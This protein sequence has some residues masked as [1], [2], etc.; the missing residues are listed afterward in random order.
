MRKK[1]WVLLFL[2]A[3]AL[4]LS[5]IDI[6][7]KENNETLH[8]PARVM[9]NKYEIVMPDGNWKEIP[10]KGV[11]MGIAKPGYF[12]GESAITYDEYYR[13]F[14]S[15]VAMNA[16]NIRIYTLH[17]PAFYEALATFNKKSEE[18]LYVFHGVWMNEDLLMSSQD[19]YEETVLNDFQEESQH[20]VDAVH[21]NITIPQRAG[22]SYGE[23][24]A[25]ISEYVLG[26]IMGV[27][28]DPQ[29]V[30][31]TNDIHKERGQFIGHFFET[32][33]ASP[34][35]HFLAQQME[36]MIEYEYTQY[37]EIRPMSFTN[38][39]TTD[40]LTHPSDSTE[41]EDIVSV[42]PNHIYTLNEMNDVGQF[43]S[44]HVYP[45][46]PEFL[47]YD[48]KYQKFMDH[49]GNIN[50][51]AAYLKELKDNHRLP[52]LVAEFG[53]P[54]SRGRTHN[55]PGMKH[56]GF[57]SEAEQGELI[58]EL[59]ED[60][61]NADYLGGIVFSWQ[62]EWF[63]RT[64]NTMDYDNPDRRPF[65]SNAQTSEQQY[66]LLS[67]DT[68][69]VLV[70]GYVKEWEKTPLYEQGL[71]V[72]HD[73]RYLY[74]RLDVDSQQKGFPVFLFDTIQDQG[75]TKI[76]GIAKGQFTNAVDFIVPI[77]G[78]ESRVMVDSYY[79][80]YNQQYGIELQMIEADPATPIKNSGD[81][82]PIRYALNNEIYLADSKKTIPF[83]YYEAGKLRE[84][85]GNPDA[86]NY[87]SLADYAVASNGT[88]ELRIPWLLLQF[89]DPSQKE[90][91]GDISQASTS[92]SQFIDT[93]GIGL[94]YIDEEGT[95]I[96]SLPELEGT[97]VP[98]FHTYTWENWDLPEVAEREKQSYYILKDTYRKY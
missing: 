36:N 41:H 68:H 91:M 32:K 71:Y 72:D 70:D 28:W 83:T 5:F 1:W 11:N 34:F 82:S 58:S 25:D 79:D 14:E 59:F 9:E 30:I 56:Q 81:F 78:N 67:F 74:V 12:P 92:A 49:R 15:I 86:S 48:E 24:T 40:L 85:N 35:E 47:I 37:N 51:Y 77:K 33:E 46:Y 63:K 18:K 3:A 31:N 13:W 87:D 45:Y 26:W 43:A 6:S 97:D 22:H 80:M 60:I 20:I 54:S 96:S 2:V 44:Y 73:E 39:V 4:I 52:I 69:K 62:D 88:I 17:P 57:I 65:W 19:P 29:V 10:I 64:W 75:N 23:Y 53:I 89:R 90:V 95:V 66:G 94:V 84:G 55:G 42:D 50:Q 7:G 98:K 38:W 16:N 93:L 21:G 8:V 27:E 76:N 61:M